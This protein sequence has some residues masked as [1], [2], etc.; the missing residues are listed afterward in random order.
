MSN[1]LKFLVDLHSSLLS[2]YPPNFKRQFK[3]EMAGVFSDSLQEAQ[4]AGIIAMTKVCLLEMIDLPLNLLRQH[5]LYLSN[6]E[7]LL[8]VESGMLTCPKCGHSSQL[9]ASYCQHCG[10]SL[11]TLELRVSNSIEKFTSSPRNISGYIRQMLDSPIIAVILVFIALKNISN[12]VF[13][14]YSDLFTP[15][16]MIAVVVV[17]YLGLVLVVWGWMKIPNYYHRGLYMIALTLGIYFLYY[18]V[19]A[20]DNLM[21]KNIAYQYDGGNYQLPG[22]LTSITESDS[23]SGSN[24]CSNWDG[25][26]I[27]WLIPP[28]SR[29]STYITISR[30]YDGS[31]TPY[32][33]SFII[34]GLLVSII[35]IFIFQRL[36]LRKMKPT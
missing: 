9:A 11:H 30:L 27:Q 24:V 34:Y 25:S 8:T 4:A 26:C 16:A 23:P 12:S 1:N 20:V 22:M 13:W 18:A 35:A 5:L 31:S 28:S 32:F 36:P 15:I 29:S 21:I 6:A 33:R 7:S 10:R 17:A 19:D 14:F 3:E 2:L